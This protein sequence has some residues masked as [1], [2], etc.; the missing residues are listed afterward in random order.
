MTTMTSDEHYVYLMTNQFNTVLFLGRT[1]DLRQRLKEHRVKRS[2]GP[3]QKN[4][5]N[6]LVYFERFTTGLDARTRENQ[7]KSGSR[8]KKEALIS[9]AN[10]NWLNLS[11]E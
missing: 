11:L 3:A 9:S 10:P 4:R 7:I 2:T 8:R 5:I 1:N 6:K